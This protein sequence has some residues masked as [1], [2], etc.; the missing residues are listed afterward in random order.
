[1]A[2]GKLSPR[3]KM[4]NMM[5]LVLIALLAMNVSAE[6]LKAFHLMEVSFENTGKS[7]EAKMKASVQGIQAEVA[8][9]GEKAKPYAERA[10]KAEKLVGEITGYLN[11]TISEIE[12]LGGGR[13][14]EDE[15]GVGKPELNKPSDTEGHANYFIDVEQNGKGKGKELRK[16]ITEKREELV[17]L[18]KATP[19]DTVYTMPK[20]FYEE[21][22]TSADLKIA[23]YKGREGEPKSWENTILVETPLAGAVTNLTRMKNEAI[24]LGNNVIKALQQGINAD[25]IKIDRMVA[26]VNAPTSYVMSGSQY[27]ADILLVAASSTANY[28]ITVNGSDLPVNGGVGKYTAQASGAGSHT[29]S[30]TIKL[31]DKTFPFSQEW[32]SFL[33]A[34]TISATKMNVLY[35]GLDNPI[36]VSVP[37][38]APGNVS[39]SMSGGSLAKKGGGKYI[40]RVRGGKEAVIRASAKMPDGSTRS[41]GAVPFRIK[42]VPPPVASLGSISGSG[43]AS[44]GSVRQQTRLFVYL[45]NFPF[46]GI[47]YTVNSCDVSVMYRNKPPVNKRVSGGNV[48]SLPAEPGS[49]VIV[50]GIRVTGPGRN[51]EIIPGSIVIDVTR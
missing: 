23:D 28:E 24:N 25:D 10:V 33:P 21:V 46:E 12:E 16:F 37:G 13:K 41:M 11:T 29:V 15:M 17:S 6:I 22:N 35:I 47:K 20:S 32:T 40:A 2:G 27:E 7:L 9:Q 49:K 30:G 38:V 45:P 51:N 3:Q 4:I 43:R 5:Y 1:M 34:A 44:V 42:R 39:V 18:L 31:G 48:G 36:E 26:M 14:E 8:K 50:G 19:G